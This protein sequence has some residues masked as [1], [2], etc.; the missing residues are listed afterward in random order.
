MG[1]IVDPAYFTSIAHR[2]F[3]RVRHVSALRVLA[4]LVPFS[5]V[6]DAPAKAVVAR[7]PQFVALAFDNCTEL[8]AWTDVDRF[9]DDMA[10]KHKTVN[11]TFF[12]SGVNLLASA[13]KNKYQ[14]PHHDRGKANIDFG[15][16][17]DDVQRRVALMNRMD[18]KGSEIASHAVGHFDANPTSGTKWTQAD[19][20]DEFDA[21]DD[22]KA[23]VANNNNLPSTV[24]LPMTMRGFR[25]PYLST[26]PGLYDELESRGFRYDTSSDGDATA[27]PKKTDGTWR[28]NLA[29]LTI[30]G[31][32]TRTLSMDYN[33]YV[34]QSN[35]TEI[36]ARA[37]EFQQQMLDT[38]V[39]YF[40]SN[41]SGNRAPLHIG[42]HFQAYQGG[43]YNQAL[44]T[45][46]ELVCG[47]PEVRCVTYSALADFMDGLSA[48]T[49]A[50]YQ[51]GDFEKLDPPDIE[52]ARASFP[53]DPPVFLLAAANKSI[54]AVVRGAT[55][56]V[57][58]I[59]WFS[60]DRLI[61]SSATVGQ[62]DLAHVDVGELTVIARGAANQVLARETVSIE[63]KLGIVSLGSEP[64]LKPRGD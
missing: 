47:L 40:R 36:P 6:A 12:I 63:R 35:A 43:V 49:L 58:R 18:S 39:D 62:R 4:L 31:T 26:T 17:P 3:D 42:H 11:F 56:N 51:R 48:S 14:G 32:S 5:A 7:P 53:E 23:N 44:R 10:S 1:H 54:K 41:Y 9:T 50:A 29:N 57:A 2:M 45:F 30:H 27:W 25:A 21:F 38:Y 28:F 37:A 22:L 34:R 8:T 13:V 15:G 19:W 60:G 61:G 59:E 20:S 24:K 16:S 46:A 55:S 33:F 64:E 52:T